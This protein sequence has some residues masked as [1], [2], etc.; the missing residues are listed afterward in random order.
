[1][2]NQFVTSEFWHAHTDHII[3]GILGFMSFIMLWKVL[4]RF[5][6]YQ[7]LDITR[8]NNIHELNIDLEENLTAIYTVGSNAPYVG[9][10]GTVVGILLT[11][12]DMGKAGGNI[13]SAQIMIGLALA[14]KATAL[15]ILVA[16]PSVMFYN[17]LARK[18]EVK[19][20]QFQSWQESEQKRQSAL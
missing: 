5:F 16:I 13:D 1:M 14:L 8:Y 7:R 19:R 12:L 18:V 17:A 10:L 4:E 11:F 2:F 20:L 9:L 3:F 15:G 6:F